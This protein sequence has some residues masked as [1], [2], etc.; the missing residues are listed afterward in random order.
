MVTTGDVAERKR[1][2]ERPS[3]LTIEYYGPGE[4]ELITRMRVSA[5][6]R[7]EPVRDWVLRAIRHELERLDRQDRAQ[8]ERQDDRPPG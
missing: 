7:K 5:V 6:Q 4:D 3:R 8:R 1:P 2:E